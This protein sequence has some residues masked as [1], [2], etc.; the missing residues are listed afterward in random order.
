MAGFRWRGRRDAFARMVGFTL[1][2]SVLAAGAAAARVARQLPRHR[3]LVP[4]DR[5]GY[6]AD[7]A[8]LAAHAHDLLARLDGKMAVA[9]HGSLLAMLSSQAPSYQGA[10]GRSCSAPLHL[11]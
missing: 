4:A 1:A 7:A 9:A 2:V 8:P 5:P 6:V 11:K 3:R 10:V